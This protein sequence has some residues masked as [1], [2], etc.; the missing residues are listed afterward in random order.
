MSASTS[1]TRPSRPTKA[2]DHAH[3]DTTQPTARTW[4]S[5]CK[6]RVLTWHPIGS[7]LRR[8]RQEVVTPKRALD[9]VGVRLAQSSHHASGV[10]PDQP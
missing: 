7:P 10:S 2:T 6:R 1:T 9:G 8:A 5:V 3:A 4:V